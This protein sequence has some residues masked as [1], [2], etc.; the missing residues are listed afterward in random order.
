MVTSRSSAPRR[1]AGSRF[2]Q[3][4]LI[5]LRAAPIP[6]SWVA[7]NRFAIPAH[8]VDE[9]DGTGSRACPAVSWRRRSS[10]T[11]WSS[12]V[13]CAQ[14]IAINACPPDRPRLRRFTGPIPAS[15]AAVIPRTR[16]SSRTASTPPARVSR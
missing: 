4:V 5:T 2:T 7:V 8:V 1:T 10:P 15:R 9:G 6:A 13:S 3:P 11:M 16:S 12:P 14:V